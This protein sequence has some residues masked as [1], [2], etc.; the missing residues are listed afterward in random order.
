MKN[1]DDLKNKRIFIFGL[2]KSGQST[3][4]LC[5]RL[6]SQITAYDSK[7]LEESEIERECKDLSIDLYY[8]QDPL[9][10]LDRPYDF[11]LKSP[12]I[13]Y[14]HPLIE[15]AMSKGL[16]VITDVEIAYHLSEAPII[17]VTGTNGKTTVTT[18]IAR[19]INQSKLSKQAYVSGN[20]GIPVCD[21]IQEL[22]ADDLLVMEL[23]SFQLMGIRHFHPHI[24][25][26]NNLYTAHL[27]YHQSRE[28]YIA[29]KMNIVSNLQGRD[30][31]VFNGKQEE[32][33]QLAQSVDSHTLSF[34]NDNRQGLD[35]YVAG[36][37]IYF[38]DQAVVDLADILI[39][40]DHN[41]ENICAAISVCK[42]LGVDDSSIQ[43]VLKEFSGVKHRMQRLG[44]VKGRIFYNDSK[45]TNV[46]ASQQA[47][48]SF[49][50]SVV[51]LAG[52][53]DRKEDLTP[54]LPLIEDKVKTLVVSGENSQ[55][56]IDLVAKLEDLTVLPALDMDEAVNLAFSY[57]DPSDIILL[58]PASASWDQYASFEERGDA[59]I[60]AVNNIGPLTRGE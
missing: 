15:K 2:G 10:L 18:L 20:I 12:G 33:H 55:A 11:M 36:G 38:K 34:A 32:L 21:V 6:G 51:W 59:F 17:G 25:V 58:S 19:M 9:P 50:G 35:T 57:S 8:D 43:L 29:A 22:T 44:Q 1:T 28:A 42:L 31:L 26:I 14:H 23:S 24:A 46:L 4:R 56:F 49:E 41:L 5:Q 45:A 48:N 3:Y 60:A 16:P 30:Y 47:L 7:N 27:D 13:P 54:L 53:L 40:G 52:G 37:Q 39:A